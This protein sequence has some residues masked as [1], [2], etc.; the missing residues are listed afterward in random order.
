MLGACSYCLI[1]ISR[2]G[3]KAQCVGNVHKIIDNIDYVVYIIYDK[4]N[5]A[6]DFWIH[7]AGWMVSVPTYWHGL[8]FSTVSRERFW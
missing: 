3:A 4:I 5:L 1:A 7:S 2:G 6:V 8:V